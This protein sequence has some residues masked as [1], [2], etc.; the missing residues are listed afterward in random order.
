M[1]SKTLALSVVYT[2]RKIKEAHRALSRK[3]AM[4]EELITELDNVVPLAGVKGD[5]GLSIKGDKGD[6]GAQGML[7]E[8]GIQGVQGLLGE[9]GI[10]GEQGITGETGE[11]GVQGMLGEQGTQGI[12][13]LQGKQGLLGEQGIQGEHGEQGITGRNGNPGESI[14]GDTGNT[15]AQGAQG[16]PGLD[17]AAGMLGEQGPQG[18]PGKTIQGPAGLAGESIKGDRGEA[19]EQGDTGPAGKDGAEPDIK[20]PMKKVTDDFN[21]WRANINKSL[22]S[23]GGGGSYKVLDNADVQMSQPSEMATNDIL[24]WDDAINKFKKLALTTVINDIRLELE[25]KFD[26]L[27]DVDGEHTYIGEATPGTVVTA[28][29]WRIRRLKEVGDDLEI[30]WA[31]GSESLTNVWNNRA[32]FTYI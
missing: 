30:R 28:A 19:G 14:K 26:K 24:I 9:Q 12:Q 18:I 25:V 31:G 17:G 20:T 8:Q 1:D 3:L 16:E 22:T 5:T 6:I 15:G 11:Q 13:G 7:G 10:Q 27:V 2:D 29:L 21:R 23:L 4:Q 32:S